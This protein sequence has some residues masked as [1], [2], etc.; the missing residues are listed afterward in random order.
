MLWLGA[1]QVDQAAHL[2]NGKFASVPWL[3]RE[4]WFKFFRLM[5]DD[6]SGRIAYRELVSGVREQLNVRKAAAAG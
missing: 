3:L 4:G 2:L 5:D 1:P 6:N